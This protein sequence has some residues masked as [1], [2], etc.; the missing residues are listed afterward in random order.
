MEAE[1]THRKIRPASRLLVRGESSVAFVGLALAAILIAAFAGGVW[2]LLRQERFDSQ[3]KATQ[4]VQSAGDLMAGSIETLLGAGE[5]STV[6][7]LV[8]D[9]ARR[10]GFTRCRVVLPDGQILADADAR[11]ITLQKLPATWASSNL[12]AVAISTSPDAVTAAMRTDPAWHQNPIQL[13]PRYAFGILSRHADALLIV[14]SN[15]RIEAPVLN[16]RIRKRCGR[17]RS[18]RSWLAFLMRRRTIP[19]RCWSRRAP[20]SFPPTQRGAT[21]TTSSKAS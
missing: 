13:Q 14:G 21:I 20:A 3:A 4:Q 9:A 2:W 18:R 6:R 17:K 1:T 5:V 19:S 8:S 15:P 12:D 16:A 10:H 7:R 11:Q